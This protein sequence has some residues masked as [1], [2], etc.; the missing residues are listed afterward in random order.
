MHFVLE[1]AQLRL[2]LKPNPRLIGLKMYILELKGAKDRNIIFKNTFHY[3]MCPFST[4][5]KIFKL[6]VKDKRFF[7]PASFHNAREYRCPAYV[8]SRTALLPNRFYE[9]HR[10]VEICR[11]ACPTNIDCSTIQWINGALLS[12]RKTYWVL[13]K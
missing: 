8:H 12:A 13:Y 10:E 1:R 3:L 9:G 6:A 11:M 4:L 2:E 5:P 7:P